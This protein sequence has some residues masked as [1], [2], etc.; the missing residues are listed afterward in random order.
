M[1]EQDI[2]RL[3]SQKTGD[4]AFQVPDWWAG[5]PTTANDQKRAQ[6]DGA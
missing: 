4:A 5:S 6:A 3:N 1:T 2:D